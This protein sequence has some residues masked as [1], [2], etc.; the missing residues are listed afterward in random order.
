MAKDIE[1][2][3]LKVPPIDKNYYIDY[4]R[5]FGNCLVFALTFWKM[6]RWLYKILRK[7]VYPVQMKQPRYPILF[8]FVRTF[9][10]VKRAFDHI[11]FMDFSIL[12]GKPGFFLW[13]LGII[14]FWRRFVLKRYHLPKKVKEIIQIER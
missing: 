4:H 14:K 9:Y 11:R 10:Y 1:D 12:P 2:R 3:G 7:K 8:A 13:K 6:P 5:T